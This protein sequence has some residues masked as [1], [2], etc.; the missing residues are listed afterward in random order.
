M[1]IFKRRIITI[2]IVLI[3]VAGWLIVSLGLITVSDTTLAEQASERVT[4]TIST[5]GL[6][7]NIYDRNG[8]TL[9][10]NEKS[11]D[12]LFYRDPDMRTETG[13]AQHTES[14]IKTVNIIESNGGTTID[15]LYIK[16]DDN[17]N[18]Y[19]DWG[20]ESEKSIAAR[21][22][23]WRDALSMNFTENTTAEQAYLKLRQIWKIPDDM[24]FEQASKVM[25]V[26]QEVVMNA[27]RAY[28]P[29]TIAY[30]VSIETVAEIEMRSDELIGIST[31]ESTV[32]K[33]P[34]STSAAHVIGYMGRITDPDE[35][36]KYTALG[37]E[38]DDLVGISGIETTMESEL[39]GNTTE[40]RGTRTVEVDKSAKITRVLDT[41]SAVDGNDVLL[42]IDM[43]LQQVA[44]K[45]LEETVKSINE[46]QKGLLVTK[47]DKYAGLR[48]DLNTIKLAEMGAVVVMDIGTGEV[49]ALANYPSFDLNMFSGGISD[50]NYEMLTKDTSLPLFNK[51]ISSKAMPGSIFKL[52]TGLAGLME[53]VITMQ[54]KIDDKS[55]YNTFVSGET[56]TDGP[57]CWT[58]TPSDH[59]QQDIIKALTN[60][61]NYYFFTVADLL[62]IDK[63]SDWASKL[64]LDSKTNIAL[65]GEATGQIGGQKVLYDNTKSYQEQKTA[66][67]KLVYKQLCSLLEG[68]LEQ[69]NMEVDETKVDACAIKLL[70]LVDAENTSIGADIRR[71]MREELGIPEGITASKYWHAEISSVLSE[72][73]WTPAQTIRTGIG[74]STVLVTPI[75]VA[76]YIS[77]LLN[78]G[79]V[80]EAQL[81]KSIVDPS[82]KVVKDIQPTV[83]SKLD[84]PE[85]YI[86]AI[87]TGMKGVVSPEDGGTA[88]DAFPDLPEKYRQE[89]GGKTGTAQ[90][91]TNT[92]TNVDLE[93]TCWFVAFTP[94]DKPEIAIVVY[95]PHGFSGSSGGLAVQEIVKFYTDRKNNKSSENIVASESIVK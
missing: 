61:C 3:L 21:F 49:L 44:E 18:Y 6:R 73:R 71:I 42:T 47:Y 23:N 5:S 33:Y 89:L 9:A 54:T 50:E 34:Y 19:Y 39:T 80:Y 70:S 29:V 74:Q 69:R 68:Y 35:L 56:I 67:P 37:Y 92:K 72:L 40:R 82:G 4:R 86:D 31:Q 20:V 16:M 41:T 94:F 45:A 15:S 2:V 75:A 48:Q 24:D 93:N 78:G 17:G 76:R 51:A 52:A 27:Y 30:N 46:K 12:V 38:N 64:G 58:K 63:L 87:K 91:S 79:T 11:Y 65:P 14:I 7:G 25:S 8:I 28:V 43:E 10:Y 85:E 59:M 88:A 13:R 22:K 62:G 95:I 32:R 26:W 60:S 1:D 36:E 57:S 77:A 90:V 66:M 55:P 84:I 81:V 53:G 83:V